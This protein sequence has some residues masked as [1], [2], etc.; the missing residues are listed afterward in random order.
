MSDSS[1]LVGIPFLE[2]REKRCCKVSGGTSDWRIFRCKR[3]DVTR[4]LSQSV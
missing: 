4:A 1:K 3:I 2:I